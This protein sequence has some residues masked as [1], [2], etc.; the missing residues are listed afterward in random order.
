MILQVPEEIQKSFASKLMARYN[1][2]TIVNNCIQC[3]KVE[4]VRYRP[5]VNPN[6][7]TVDPILMAN[8]FVCDE[9][10]ITFRQDLGVRHVVTKELLIS[11]NQLSIAVKFLVAAAAESVKQANESSPEQEMTVLRKRIEEVYPSIQGK[12]WKFNVEPS[13]SDPNNRIQ[14]VVMPDKK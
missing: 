8:A 9:N 12:E 7:T 6:D 2:K 1:S 14:I 5:D 11:F 13:E 3:V 4:L 10:G